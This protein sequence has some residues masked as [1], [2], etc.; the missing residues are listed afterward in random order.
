MGR[1]FA[2]RVSHPRL[3]WVLLVAWLVLAALAAPPAG[4]L[5]GQQEDD[6]TQLGIAVALGVLLDTVVVRSGLV[7]ALTLD[8][9][10]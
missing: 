7:T 8:V 1:S 3:E 4:R 2:S 10:R 6:L 9:G 5:T